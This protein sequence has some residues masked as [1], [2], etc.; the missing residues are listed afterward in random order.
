VFNLQFEAVTDHNNWAAQE[1]ATLLFAIL[2]G[3]AAEILR[4]VPDGATNLG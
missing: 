4:I 3:H 1:K 2:Q